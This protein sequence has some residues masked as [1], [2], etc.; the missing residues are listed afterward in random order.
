MNEEVK[1]KKNK[2]EKTGKLNIK[3][4][5]SDN[6]KAIIIAVVAFLVVV[7]VIIGSV[8]LFGK[9]NALPNQKEHMESRLK[10]LA[11]EF[12]EVQYY[13][14]L[15][16]SKTGEAMT[17]DEKKAF[18]QKYKDTGITIDLASLARLYGDEKDKILE[19][20]KNNDKACNYDNTKVVI[21]PKDPYNVSSYE[22][23]I[24]LD[25]GFEEEK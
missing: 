16:N 5:F 7:L 9:S 8:T 20:F 6:K 2:K 4:F 18:A 11:K 10:E 24:I 13:P 21:Y 22:V 23:K 25:C 17:D 12:Y 19:E 14:N 3:K 1:E 15:A